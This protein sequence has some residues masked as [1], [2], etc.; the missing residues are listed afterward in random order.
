MEF[1]GFSWRNNGGC[2]WLE[3]VEKQGVRGLYL[4]TN[5]HLF[6]FLLIYFITFTP[7]TTLALQPVLSS[8]IP[9]IL[10][11]LSLC[12]PLHPSHPPKHPHQRQYSKTP[13]KHRNPHIPPHNLIIA[14]EIPKHRIPHALV[15]RIKMA[16]VSASQDSEVV[17]CY[18]YVGSDDGAEEGE[19]GE[20]EEGRTERVGQDVGVGFDLGRGSYFG[21]GR[22]GCLVGYEPDW[23]G[24]SCVDS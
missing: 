20:E 7:L 14:S 19:E 13:Q 21:E 15:I 8:P 3:L 23:V 16:H 6:S 10:R 1:M 2:G 11:Y 18:P 17:F 5:L 24:E 4:D 12:R 9:S 22:D